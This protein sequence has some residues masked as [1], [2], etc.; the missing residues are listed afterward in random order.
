M[1][2]GESPNGQPM[3]TMIQLYCTFERDFHAIAQQTGT[4]TGVVFA[5]C[6]DAVEQLKNGL[7]IAAKQALD[8]AEEEEKAKA[9]AEEAARAQKLAEA[10]ERS[11]REALESKRTRRSTKSTARNGGKKPGV[12]R[13]VVASGATVV[14]RGRPKGSKNKSRA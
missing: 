9:E 11:N 7:K 3:R 10:E 4:N 14:R 12:G 5:E 1:Q 13:S 2:R 8:R 6:L